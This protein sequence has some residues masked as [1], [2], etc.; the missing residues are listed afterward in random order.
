MTKLH[1]G[2]PLRAQLSAL[3]E[4]AD[5]VR[6]QIVATKEG[7]A[8]TGEE[9]LREHM[10]NLYGG[11]M[12]YE[13]RPTATLIAYTGVLRRELDDV[14]TEFAAQDAGDVKAANAA[15]KA[16]GLPEITGWDESQKAASRIGAS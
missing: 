13:G 6:K 12:D 15:L 1:E 8:I 16:R 5:T 3:S 9:R 11:I 7:G 4:M 2:D 14:S 10:D